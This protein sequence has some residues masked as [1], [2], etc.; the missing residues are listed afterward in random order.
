MAATAGSI[1]QAARVQHIAGVPPGVDPQRATETF[2]QYKARM[3]AAGLN[4]DIDATESDADYLIRIASYLPAVPSSSY[5]L[6]AL[7]AVT[8]TS[9][10]AGIN[11]LFILTDTGSRA[12]TASFVSGELTSLTA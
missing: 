6:S 11:G 12:W 3:A 1:Y 9:T 7:T 10:T 8:A 4:P 2:D 5:A